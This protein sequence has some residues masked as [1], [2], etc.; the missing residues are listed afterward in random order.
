M[1]HKLLRTNSSSLSESYGIY[2][3]TSSPGFP[4]ANGESE[5]AVQIAKRILR[6]DDPALALM[7]YCSTPVAPTGKSLSELMLGRRIRTTLPA[8]ARQFRYRPPDQQVVESSEVH[9][10]YE[11]ERQYN[12]RQGAKDL[13]PLKPGDRVRVRLDVE[14]LWSKEGTI[15][16]PHDTPR[17]YIVET[18]DG[19]TYRLNRKHLLSVPPPTPP[20]QP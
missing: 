16:Q 12:K 11:Y 10:K 18:S 4:Q 5:R 9:A 19:G 15:V 3:T 8:V 1:V 2:I 14:K 13:P 17:S 6:Q 7:T 20:R